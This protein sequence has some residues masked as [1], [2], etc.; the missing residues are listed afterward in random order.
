M[1]AAGQPMPEQPTPIQPTQPVDPMS[2]AEE[3]MNMVEQ[4]MTEAI[5]EQIE[6]PAMEPTPVME[7]PKTK[8]INN[9]MIG[10]VLAI[11]V[12]VAGIAFGVI[13]M[14]NGNS[15]VADLEKQISSLK[16]TNSN[17]QSE[18]D[19]V[20]P[21]NGD[22]ALVLLQSAAATQGLPY[23]IGYANVFAKYNGNDDVVAYWVKYLPVNVP[24]G[25]AVASDIIFTM[26]ADGEWEFTLPGFTGYTQE[27]INNYV[28]L[29]GNALTIVAT[30]EVVPENPEVTPE[31]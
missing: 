22:E 11:V 24:E 18:L 25:V 21:L 27:L 7:A 9:M 23:G 3:P 6:Q 15:Q 16:A 26:N 14:L 30:P 29:D 17:L 19:E 10:L 4:Q 20:E 28:S 8:K 13:M 12:A 1:G 31:E 2:M 5:Q